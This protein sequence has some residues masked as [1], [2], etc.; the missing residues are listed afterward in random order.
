M[1]T[2]K[3]L[4]DSL[5][6]SGTTY[7]PLPPKQ[8]AQFRVDALNSAVGNRNEQD[9]YDCKICKNRGYI[10]EIVDNGDGSYSHAIRDCKCAETRKSIL[11]M[12]KS[13]L[14]DVIRKYTF[15]SFEVTEPWQKTLKDAAVAYAK[16]PDGWFALCGQSGIGKSH[17]CTAICR[18]LLL[19]G[20]QVQYMLWRDD[21]VKI[22]QAAMGAQ[23]DDELELNRL[24]N[25]FKTAKV[26]YIDDFFKTG[27]PA[28]VRKMQPSAADISYAFEIINYRYNNPDLITIIST[29]LTEDELLDIDEAIGGR[30]YERAK[31]FSIGKDRRKNYRVRNTVE[32]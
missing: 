13:G 2:I 21:I 16:E 11:R 18:E 14:K 7:E 1:E 9:G 20:E 29:E 17:L 28:D 30:I 3:A 8:Y 5:S 27:T 26:L 15:D 25:G 24:L 10:A 12:Q 4:L 19:R 23:Y 31:A 22:K 32:I 6:E